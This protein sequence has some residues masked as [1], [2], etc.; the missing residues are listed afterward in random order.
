[1]AKSLTKKRA[2]SRKRVVKSS[3]KP[4]RVVKSQA[5]CDKVCERQKNEL[6]AFTD[7]V[8]RQLKDSHNTRVH[9]LQSELNDIRKNGGGKA[10]IA[11]LVNQ[12]NEEKQNV[13]R[14]LKEA[15][16]HANNIYQENL[17]KVNAELFSCHQLTK[18]KDNRISELEADI[19]DLRENGGDKNEIA[20]LKAQLAQEKREQ[21]QLGTAIVEYRSEIKDFKMHME[22][23]DNRISELK[24]E[25]K[26]LRENGGDK[27]EIADLKAQL[28]KMK[29]SFDSFQSDLKFSCDASKEAIQEAFRIEKEEL[30]AEI[31]LLKKLAKA[32]SIGPPIGGP[33]IGPPISNGGG[34]PVMP[35][36]PKVP[37]NLLSE[38]QKGK[39]L[40]KTEEVKD[41]SKSGLFQQIKE[42]TQLRKVT[43]DD[44]KDENKN[45]NKKK[46]A[47][48]ALVEKVTSMG[49]KIK[50]E[51]DDDDDEEWKLNFRARRSV[52]RGKKRSS[53]KRS[54]KKRSP[55]K[56]SSK[57][58]SSK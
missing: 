26:D 6:R 14:R 23:K 35:N 24:A 39:S 30:S 54:S 10:E 57:K 3:A 7:N 18:N 47:A 2:K 40:I 36:T 41:K 28:K 27:N 51:E 21:E 56:R 4:K 44:N 45:K 16:D 55:K 29:E 46:T 11:S 37:L 9:Q 33:P 50:G 22:D 38:I 12:L 13:S 32:T 5:N 49:Q 1:M 34:P 15:V 42:G 43:R 19:K 8:I 31:A 17:K 48:E 20:D 58:R 25:I 52:K 53:K